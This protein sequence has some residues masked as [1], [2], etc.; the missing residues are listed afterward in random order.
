MDNAFINQHNLS[1]SIFNAGNAGVVQNLA[2]RVP[3]IGA[4][5][6]GNT[7][8]TGA[9]NTINTIPGVGPA[10]NNLENNP[11]GA[12]TN[13]SGL[14]LQGGLPSLVGGGGGAGSPGLAN[15]G[16]NPLSEAFSL[17]SSLGA[18]SICLLYTSPS[19]RD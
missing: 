5:L 8:L 15:G 3:N 17:A 9:L 2:G 13:F 19:P 11:L 14:N 1:Q 12:L 10:L 16:A 4:L 18:S 7:S 6:N